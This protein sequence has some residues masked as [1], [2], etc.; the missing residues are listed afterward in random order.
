MLHKN[1][2]YYLSPAGE[3]VSHY[4]ASLERHV[5]EI[6]QATGL[7]ELKTVMAACLRDMITSE[8]EMCSYNLAG[9]AKATREQK[10]EVAET[11]KTRVADLQGVDGVQKRREEIIAKCAA[12]R[13]IE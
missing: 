2:R 6:D 12:T 4:L 7:K 11:I 3:I 9:G 8:L 1:P 13:R 10:A 5:N